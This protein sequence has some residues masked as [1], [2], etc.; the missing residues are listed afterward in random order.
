MLQSTDAKGVTTRD[1]FKHAFLDNLFYTQGKFPALA[2]QND[3]YKALAYTVRDQLLSRWISTAAAYTKQGSRTVAYLS[4]EFLMGPHLGNNL[5]NLDMYEE[6]RAAITELGLDFEQLLQLE[7]EPGLG[8]GGLGRLAA[9]FIDSMAT[10]ELPCLGY[11]IRYEFGIFHQEIIDGWQQE[12]TDN[13]LRFGNPWEIQRPEWSVEVKFRGHTEQYRD[14]QNRLRV[15][16]VPEKEVIG[17]PYDTPILGYRNNTANTLRLWTS[18][19]PE[20]FDFSTFNRGDHHGAVIRKVASENISKVL[21]PNDEQLQGKELRLEQQYFFVSCSLQDMF[22]ILRTQRLAVE[23]FPE[24]FAIQLNDTHPAIAVAELM[25]LLIDEHVMA[26]DDAWSI[27]TRTFAYTNHTLMPEALECWPIDLFHRVLP[28]H[29]EIIY[30]IN[31]NFLDQVRIRFLGDEERLARLSLID[32]R[33]E[34]YVRMAHLACVGAHTING[35]AALHSE[36]LKT[37]VLRDFYELWPEKFQNKTNGV[38]PRRWM[39]LANPSLAKLITSS[40]GTSWI[41][42]LNE[43]R[44]LEPLADDAGFRAEWL[45]IKQANKRDFAQ[46]AL[47]RTGVVV[48]PESMF[49]V[50][51]KRIHEYK[52]Q[53]LNILHVIALYLRLKA[54]PDLAMPSRT[55]VFGGKAAPGYRMAKLIIK[56]INAVGDVVNRDTAIRDRLKVVY[57]PNFN[58]SNGHRIYPA[59]DLSEQISTA[60]KEASGTGNMKFTMNGALT[61]GT[62]DGA[63]VEIREQV[64]AENFFL[65]GHSTEEVAE[66]WRRGYR[67][68]EA[69]ARD[70]LLAEVL[71]LIRSGF[72]SRGDTEL[73]RPLL[74]NLTWHDPYL[75]LADFSSYR[76]C[77]Q[78]VSAAYTDMD[79]W[80]RMS[81]LN[82]ARSGLFSSDRT[83]REYARDIWHTKP[84]S[85]RL[86]SEEE[87]KVGFL[88]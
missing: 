51:V 53:H 36:L 37:D 13:W 22:R 5:I 72:F 74:D 25:R 21:Y 23:R 70:P 20:S 52:R 63:N 41:T 83:I 18:E 80:V 33:G 43:L 61:I 9:C 31:A 16:W 66:V 14:E 71:D 58:V 30:E 45:A 4:A 12:R 19:A 17:V 49:D 47:E 46:L 60:G 11:G 44:R 88:Q 42:D 38:T 78:K 67:P 32:E 86:L 50:Q 3:Y 79:S 77:Q 8:N 48:D 54:D 27:V 68:M 85:V 64:G 69:A 39:V 1:A 84:V 57:L 55:F 24:K 82:S 35:V 28:R 76:D 15:R 87:V 2:T 34:R 62:M 81:I 6:V 56:L 26:W 40:I 7:Q 73:F 65:F 75:V 10:V 59:A 29:L